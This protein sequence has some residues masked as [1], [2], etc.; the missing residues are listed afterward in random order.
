MVAKGN[1]KGIEKL[2]DLTK[3]GLK[4]GQADESAAAVGRLTPKI[5]SL[6]GVDVAA[7][8]K[9]VV[10]T[11]PTVN[12][13]AVAVKLKTIDATVVWKAIALNYIKDSDI[14][15]IPADKNIMPEV[16]VAVLL[17]SSN[18][19]TAKKFIDF[20]VS[21]KGREILIANGYTVG[22]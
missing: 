10:M 13:L 8:K 7:W 16:G 3:P 4:I 19:E 9:N 5:M 11:T 20:M 22:E 2:S 18:K 12:E 21:E 14:I 1:P 6:N 15:S 17:S